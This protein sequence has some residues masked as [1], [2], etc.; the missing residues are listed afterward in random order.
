MTLRKVIAC[1]R[2]S[3]GLAIVFA[4]F[5]ANAQSTKRTLIPLL[6]FMNGKDFLHDPGAVQYLYGRCAGLYTAVTK[7]LDGET[8]PDRVNL[9]EAYNKAVGDLMDAWVRVDMIGTT[10]SKEESYKRVVRPVADAANAYVDLFEEA[11]T[12]TGDLSK[13]ATVSSDTD[14]CK[15]VAQSLPK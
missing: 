8:A 12:Y 4:S 3:L 6:T 5:D 10:F 13:D 2:A 9:Q 14:V 15:S 1:V 11:R 7:I